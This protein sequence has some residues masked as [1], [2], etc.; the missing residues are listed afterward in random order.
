MRQ[1]KCY[2]KVKQLG[3]KI[4]EPYPPKVGLNLTSDSQSIPAPVALR[5]YEPTESVGC[6][7]SL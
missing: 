7:R 4:V 5:Q 6:L 2:E 3:L 1:K